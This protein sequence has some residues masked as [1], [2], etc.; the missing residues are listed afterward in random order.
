[1]CESSV[2]YCGRLLRCVAVLGN[3]LT[4]NCHIVTDRGRQRGLTDSSPQ[5]DH[6]IIDLLRYEGSSDSGAETKRSPGLSLLVRQL[7]PDWDSAGVLWRRQG[8]PDLGTRG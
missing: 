1:M 7:E 2:V 5:I 3:G 8:H 6:Y 4:V